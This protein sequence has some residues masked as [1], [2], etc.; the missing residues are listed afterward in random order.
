MCY[1]MHEE[2]ASGAGELIN[3]CKSIEYNA[4]CARPRLMRILAGYGDFYL[5][6]QGVRLGGIDKAKQDVHNL[7]RNSTSVPSC[8][9]SLFFIKKRKTRK[10]T[11]RKK[12]PQ[13]LKQARARKKLLEVD[14]EAWEEASL[15]TSHEATALHAV[16]CNLTSNSTNTMSNGRLTEKS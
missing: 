8:H 5:L 1:W 15:V 16:A 6:R 2:I 9:L 11:N 12:E 14:G 10:E 13:K 4:A 7:F 3:G